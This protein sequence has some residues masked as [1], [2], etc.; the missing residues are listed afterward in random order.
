M[1]ALEHRLAVIQIVIALT[2]VKIKNIDG[3]DLLDLVILVANL[4]MLG[5]GFRHTIQ[6]ALQVVELAR[7]LHLHDDNLS[8]LGLGLDVHTVKLVGGILLVAL[9]LKNL[10]DFYRHANKNGYQSLQHRK[11]G[12]IA[13]HALH[14]PVKPDIFIVFRHNQF[15][16]VRVQM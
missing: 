11:I 12:L 16:I 10:E 8:L 3:I 5:N 4:Y 6:H 13:Q 15:I 7:Q 1:H 2:E 14:R 9:A